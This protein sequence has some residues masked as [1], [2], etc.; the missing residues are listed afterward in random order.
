MLKNVNENSTERERS[1]F[2]ARFQNRFYDLL[3]STGSTLEQLTDVGLA[4]GAGDE[5]GGLTILKHQPTLP[6]CTGCIYSRR[7]P[8]LKRRFCPF[9]GARRAALG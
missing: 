6:G 3:D 9:Q 2:S 4:W 1:H 8:F 5:I 7:V